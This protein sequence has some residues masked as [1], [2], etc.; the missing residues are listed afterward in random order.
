MTT[1]P[2]TTPAAIPLAATVVLARDSDYGLQVLMTKRAAGLSFMA[3]LWVF[4]GGRVEAGDSSRDLVDADAARTTLAQL[5]PRMRGADGA[6]LETAQTLAILAAA[7]RETFEES[8]LLLARGR[9]D[10]AAPGPDQLRRVN[11]TR[12]PSVHAAA[13]AALLRAEKLVLDIGRLVYW[14]HWITPALEGKR[15]DTRFFAIEAPPDQVASVDQSELTHHA[16]LDETD[17]RRGLESGEMKMA[18]PTQAT[19]QDLWTSHA[20][21]GTVAGLLGAE[22]VG[23][24]PPILPGVRPTAV[25]DLEVVLPWYGGY[26]TTPGERWEWT[27]EYPGHLQALPSRRPT[28]QR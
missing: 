28:R 15:F 8:G 9:D 22:R 1:G 24:V 13:F 23:R 19:L 18:P 16:W 11:E 4:P 7:C 21:H 2:S 27:G 6:P 14:S 17:V 3:G 25:G 20:R 10:G 12:A 26:A 5:G